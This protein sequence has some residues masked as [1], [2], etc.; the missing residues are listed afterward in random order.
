MLYRHCFSNSALEYTI[1]RVLVNE[2][3]LKLNGPPQLLVYA[4]VNI[5]GGNV[6][7]IKNTEV[8][9]AASK[10]NGLEA[11]AD[12]AKYMVIYLDQNAGLSQN[13]KI[14]NNS[15]K[16]WNNSHL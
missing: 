16:G 4:D 3:G 8:V 7:A 9:V 13:I 1:R 2:D 6:H 14:D 15:L 5:L 12:K 11:N 10:E